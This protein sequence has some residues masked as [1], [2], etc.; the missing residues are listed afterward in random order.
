MLNR[1]KLVTFLILSVISLIFLGACDSDEKTD[2]QI[3]GKASI[4]ERGVIN[5]FADGLMTSEG[6]PASCE[7]SAVVYQGTNLIIGSDQ[8][9]P[10]DGLSSVFAIKYT[11][12]GLPTDSGLS[13]EPVS[14]LTAPPFLTATKYEDFTLTPD[15]LYVIATTGFDRVKSDSA[16]WDGYNTLLFWKVGSPETVT[17]VSPTTSDGI[18]SSVSLRE[19]ISVVLKSEQ[20]P[21]GVPYF[22]VEGLAAIPGNK[23][24]FGIRELGANYEEFEYAAK[25]ISVSYQIRNGNVLELADDFKLIY[26]YDVSKAFNQ[27]VGLSSLEYDKH[28]D[29][30]Y[31][32]TSF[33]ESETDEGLGGYLWTLPIA[34]LKSGKAPTLEIKEDGTPLLFAHKS[35]G[36][37]VLSKNKVLVIHDDDRVL[38]RKKVENPETQ[39]SRQANQ[40]AYSIVFWTK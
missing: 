26:S 4:I 40:G 32:L 17:V 22:K 7:T 20:F 28:S 35:E 19:K 16:E 15:G 1:H 39:F 10:K 24:L 33:E 30:L 11:D 34:D 38:G 29:R 25:I 31:L 27:T 13:S 37:S 18:T 9:I 5:C 12:N 21:K 14:Y 3:G 8:P 2:G 23:L 36:I 6:K